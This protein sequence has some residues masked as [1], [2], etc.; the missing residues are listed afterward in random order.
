MIHFGVGPL[1]RNESLLEMASYFPTFL[2]RNHFPPIP[3]RHTTY[4]NW[5]CFSLTG[6]S[7]DSRAVLYTPIFLQLFF[8]YQFY[9]SLPYIWLLSELPYCSRVLAN[10]YIFFLNLSSCNE[11][12]YRTSLN[13]TISF[14]QELKRTDYLI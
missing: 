10:L 13:I 9:S 8:L 6:S 11:S 3:I 4:P 7:W 12:L 14:K 5:G 2:F 1:F